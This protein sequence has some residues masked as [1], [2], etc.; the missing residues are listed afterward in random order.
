MRK[1]ITN[2][3]GQSRQSTAQ[4]AQHMVTKI[5]KEQGF[6]EVSILA[7]A[8]GEDSAQEREKRV[9]A[10]LANVREGDIIVAQMPTWNGIVFD[11]VLL[12]QLRQR[13]DK[14]VV[15]VHDFVPLMFANNYYLMDRYIAA[16]NL[17]DLVI[18]PSKK[19]EVRLRA[20]ELQVPVLTQD[21][22]DLPT[23]FK[24]DKLPQMQ[25]KVNFIGNVNRFPF[26]A[27]WDSDLPLEVYSQGD[28]ESLGNVVIKDWC[29]G[30]D[31]LKNLSMGGFGLVWSENLIEQQQYEREYSKINVSFKFSTYLAAGLPIIVNEGLAKEE[32]VKKYKLGFVAKD[33]KQVVDSVKKLSESEYNEY[34]ENVQKISKLIKEGYFTRKLLI[35]IEQILYL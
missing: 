30:D 7:Y 11:E 3:H 12:K 8:T 19:M 2:L 9:Q 27:S 28:L 13:T 26:V 10:M 15:F 32:F 35:N 6:E 4:V 17:S 24:S 1:Y 34:R 33:L 21:I 5:A 23:N 25:Q 14:L 16:Y 31:L 20:E 29:E 18:L 22:W